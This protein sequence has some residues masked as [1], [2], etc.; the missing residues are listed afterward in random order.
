LHMDSDK[1]QAVVD[2]PTPDSRKTLQRFLG[3]A[4]F[5]QHFVRNFH[6]NSV[7]MV[8]R[9]KSCVVSAPIL[10]APDPSR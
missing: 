9:S 7:Q 10:I 8:Q 4:N 5:Y 2:W 3:F 6:Q 1:I